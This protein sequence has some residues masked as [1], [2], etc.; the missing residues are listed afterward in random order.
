MFLDDLQW[1]GRTP[2]GFMDLVLSDEPIDGLLLVGAYRDGNLDGAHPLAALLS[3]WNDQG[4]VRHIR[5][6]NLPGPTL[7]DMVA[8]M[9]HVERERAAGLVTAIE[10]HTRGNP[11][12]TVEL[13][14]ALRRDGVLTATADGWQW[15]DA[16]ARARLRRSEVAELLG[17]RIEQLGPQSRQMVEA[18]ACLGG[19]AELRLLQ[20]ATGEPAGA[21]EQM[22]APALEEGLLVLDSGEREAGRFR[23]DRI[24]E[25]VLG[26]LDR[27][28]RRALQLAIAR[29]L[30]AV[31]EWFAVAAEQYLPV[32]DEVD[33]PT[34]RQRVVALLRRAADQARLIGDYARVER[35]AC[36]RA[37][38][39]RPSRRRH[40][41]R[42]PHRPS[43]RPV[44]PG[45]S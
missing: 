29:R 18:M 3:R 1:A 19:R 26:G 14:D 30:A 25:V 38:A 45:S 44:Q 16:V 34:E 7:V 41:A 37:A 22:L 32:V 11:Y 27:Q 42:A 17:A 23:H 24:R 20:A 8:E 15:D 2:L 12:E 6:A 9:L 4:G 5:L 36:G 21:V 33:D 40:G 35:T 43:R 28:R 39:G 31:P 13:L 10:P